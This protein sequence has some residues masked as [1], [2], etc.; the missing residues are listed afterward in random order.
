[1]AFPFPPNRLIDDLLLK[2]AYGNKKRANGRV[3]PFAPGNLAHFAPFYFGGES[4]QL[5]I[6]KQNKNSA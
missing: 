5:I 4:N 3:G 6:I 2:L 1:V